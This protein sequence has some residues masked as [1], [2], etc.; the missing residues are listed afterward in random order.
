M[1]HNILFGKK[2]IKLFPQDKISAL[3][4]DI[5]PAEAFEIDSHF[6]AIIPKRR[7]FPV[8]QKATIQL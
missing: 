7:S 1:K 6:Y 2:I 4:G 8:S 5:S 3:A